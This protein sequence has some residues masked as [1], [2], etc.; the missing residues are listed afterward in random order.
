MVEVTFFENLSFM[1]FHFHGIHSLGA[2]S[3]VA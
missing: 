2:F 1:G 3:L